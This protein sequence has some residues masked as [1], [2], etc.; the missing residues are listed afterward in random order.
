VKIGVLSDIHV[1][2]NCTDKDSVT[3]AIVR[4]IKENSLDMMIIAGDIASDYQLT[5]GSLKEIEEKGKVPCLFVPG[6]HDI[7]TENHTEKN[8]WEIYE[9]L[10]SF[11]HN[12]AN[13]SYE[14][15]NN[16]VII[17]D[18]G[19]YDFS[20]GDSNK[21]NVE[22]FS[23][24]KYEERVWQ[25]SINAVWNR[26]TMDMHRYFLDKLENQLKMY[27]NKNIIVVTHVLPIVDFT[28]LPPSP[29]WEYMNAFLGSSEYG[30]LIL[31]YPNVKYAISGHVHYRK[32]KVINGTEFI[33]NCL[34]YKNEWYNNDDPF[35]EI[36]RAMMI[37]NINC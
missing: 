12:L 21:Y 29:M 33:C 32:R 6:N 37:I 3:P 19:W 13:K 28:V 2:I 8:S 7:W 34:G 11:T 9:L 15:C 36:N 30:E 26:S 16:W 18:L 10:K 4:N 23:Q 1:D 25:D 24:M 17:G 5:L 22:N 20:F 31:K 27:A 35:V 14:P